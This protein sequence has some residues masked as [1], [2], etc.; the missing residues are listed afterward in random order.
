MSK[1]RSRL[2]HFS[3][4]SLQCPIISKSLRRNPTSS[5]FYKLD[6]FRKKIFIMGTQFSPLLNIKYLNLSLWHWTNIDY[7]TKIIQFPFANKL[8]FN[9]RFQPEL[10]FCWQL[11]SGGPVSHTLLLCKSLRCCSIRKA[12]FFVCF[13]HHPGLTYCRKNLKLSVNVSSF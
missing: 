3:E 5:V 8:K 11:Q 13:L 7:N 9:S 6:F 4:T 1:L 10:P 2:W 12:M